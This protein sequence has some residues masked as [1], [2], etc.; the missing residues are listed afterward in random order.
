MKQVLNLRI[1]LSAPNPGVDFAVQYGKGNNYDIRL[2]QRS[3]ETDLCFEFPVEVKVTD[4][5]VDFAGANVHGP[6]NGR[7]I[8]IDIGRS[9]G[10]FDSP[11]QRRLKVPLE[12]ISAVTVDELLNNPSHVLEIIVPGKAKDGGPKIGSVV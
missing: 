1:I 9:A 8:Y 10:Q 4:G 3:G 11:W 5:I 6:R 7:F 2:K 12:D